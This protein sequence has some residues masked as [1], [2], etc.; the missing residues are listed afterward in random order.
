MCYNDTGTSFAKNCSTVQL[1]RI[2]TVAADSLQLTWSGQTVS[3]IT[4]MICFNEHKLAAES[5]RLTE[6]QAVVVNAHDP[7]RALMLRSLTHIATCNAER[8]TFHS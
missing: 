3:A 7:K 6:D 5:A 8:Q 2:A 1:L 4:L